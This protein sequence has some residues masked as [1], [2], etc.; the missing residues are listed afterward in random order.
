MDHRLGEHLRRSPPYWTGAE[1]GALSIVHLPGG[2]VRDLDQSLSIT[3]G[4]RTISAPSSIVDAVG[5]R[6]DLLAGRARQAY[7]GGAPLALDADDRDFLA[8][9]DREAVGGRRGSARV[10]PGEAG[11]GRQQTP[12]VDVAV[13]EQDPSLEASSGEVAGAEAGIAP[14]RSLVPAPTSKPMSWPA[15]MTSRL[16]QMPA[17]ADELPARQPS[18][19]VPRTP[20]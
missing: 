10:D 4:W 9:W 6:D 2:G 16:A 20:S 19:M 17:L 3:Q 1:P 11:R 13:V 5:H 7:L 18:A 12:L 8:G 15:R 14:G